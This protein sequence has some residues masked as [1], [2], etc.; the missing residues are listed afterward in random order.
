MTAALIM[1]V[2]KSILSTV[3]TLSFHFCF[4]NLWFC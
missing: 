3:K 4:F 2:V 1:S